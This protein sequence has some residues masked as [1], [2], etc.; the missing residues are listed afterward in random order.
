MGMGFEHPKV[1]ISQ[2]TRMKY[3]DLGRAAFPSPQ[4]NLPWKS[5]SINHGHALLRCSNGDAVISF[6]EMWCR[7]HK[8][9]PF[10]GGNPVVQQL[11]HIQN[12]L[13]LPITLW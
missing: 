6:R 7:M 12:M 8:N 10:L 1:G 3:I 4:G 11:Q 5:Y 2:L 9:H 13:G